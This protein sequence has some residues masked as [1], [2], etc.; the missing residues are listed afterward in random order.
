[1]CSPLR[2]RVGHI[3]PPTAP[4]GRR[5]D[6]PE[7]GNAG[8]ESCTGDGSASDFWSSGWGQ[9]LNSSIELWVRACVCIWRVA[10]GRPEVHRFRERIWTNA[11]ESGFSVGGEWTFKVHS[12]SPRERRPDRLTPCVTDG[13]W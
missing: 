13:D 4:I 7:V 2:R 1:M 5:W 3:G 9:A 8:Q 11:R 6:P 12:R 10:H